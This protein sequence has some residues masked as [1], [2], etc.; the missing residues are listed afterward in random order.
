MSSKLTLSLRQQDLEPGSFDTITC[1]SVTKWVH[2]N[3]GDEALQALL[4]KVYG[5]LAPGGRFVVEPQQWVSYK[6]A[7]RKPVSTSLLFV[8][9]MVLPSQRVLSSV[10]QPLQYVAVKRPYMRAIPAKLGFFQ[11]KADPFRVVI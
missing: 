4:A 3:G 10:N 1:F 11:D 5:L 8:A 7:L 2:L 6:K 9:C